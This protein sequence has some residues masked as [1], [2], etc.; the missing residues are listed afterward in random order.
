M[1]K[2]LEK[3]KKFFKELLAFLKTEEEDEAQNPSSPSQQNETETHENP[4][5]SSTTED[6]K[7]SSFG[8]PNCAKA[9]EDPKVQIKDLKWST[10]QLSYK[11]KS[12]T[13]LEQ[14]EITNPHDAQALACF[15]YLD[16]TGV[17]R[18]CKID[19]I[20]SD[21]LSRTMTNVNEGY[22]GID[23]K[24]YFAAKEHGFFIMEKNGK[25]RS[26]IIFA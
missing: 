19:W 23:P 12:S 13:K 7:Y 14:W 16:Q 6:F 26:N 21:R 17:W 9:K 18:F 15:G 8:S 3:V 1:K 20:S 4:P 24:V 10:K 22:N 5:S 11:W 25:R 2:I